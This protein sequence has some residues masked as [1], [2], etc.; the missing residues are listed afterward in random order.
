MLLR[1]CWR[2]E[3]HTAKPGATFTFDTGFKSQLQVFVLWYL[4]SRFAF[5]SSFRRFIRGV[6]VLIVVTSESL[7]RNHSHSAVFERGVYI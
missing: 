7:R 1:C 4:C 5:A 3:L 6:V 2:P